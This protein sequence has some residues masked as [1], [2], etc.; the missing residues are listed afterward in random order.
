MQQTAEA[1]PAQREIGLRPQG[2]WTYEDWLNFPDDGWKYE[3]ID[4]E[5]QMTPPPG[6]GHQLSSGSL[7]ARLYLYV[8]DHNLG[9]VLEAPCAVRLPTQTVPLEPDIFFVRQEKLGI[10][11]EKEVQGV[12]D[13]IVEI[14][15]PSNASY[16]RETKFA[17]YQQAGVP[18]YWLMDYQAKTVE[19][20]VLQDGVYAPA[21]T[22]RVGDTV[23]AAVVPGFTIAVATIFD[24]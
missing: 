3:I 2:S 1:T 22:Y 10:I 8:E 18:E 13:L 20:F 11:A 15:S 19:C 21:G 24:F 23:S 4:G 12:P 6:T 9:K 16:D 14:L 5:L 17:V 7:F